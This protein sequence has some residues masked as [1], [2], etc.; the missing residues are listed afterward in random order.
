MGPNG[1]KWFCQEGR[2]GKSECMKKRLPCPTEVLGEER[3]DVVED[4]EV[5]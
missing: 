2:K 5:C 3:A 1:Q 4:A